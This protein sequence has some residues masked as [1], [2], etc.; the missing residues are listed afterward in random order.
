MD[1]CFQSGYQLRN[2]AGD[3]EFHARLNS[4]GMAGRQTVTW[5]S[6]ANKNGCNDETI[7]GTIVIDWSGNG[8][9]TFFDYPMEHHDH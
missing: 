8:Q 2:I 6:D 9:N 1:L 5:C 4:A 7:K 3:K